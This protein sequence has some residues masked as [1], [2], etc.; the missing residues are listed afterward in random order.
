[1]HSFYKNVMALP[2]FEDIM[3]SDGEEKN[4]SEAYIRKH[5]QQILML[6]FNIIQNEIK[7]DAW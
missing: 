6:R 1:M 3:F 7:S 4:Y 5:S 2:A